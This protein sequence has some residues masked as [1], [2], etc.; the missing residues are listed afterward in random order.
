MRPDKTRPYRSPRRR[1]QAAETRRHI[2]DA[3][4][5]LFVDRGLGATS[6]ADIARA[7]G[8]ATPTVY[9]SFGSKSALLLAVLDQLT[10]AAG[11]EGMRE[12]LRSHGDDPRAQLAAYVHFDRVLFEQGRDIIGVGLRARSDPEIDAWFSEGE[13]RRRA[14][15]APVVRG[16][17]RAGVLRPGL[18]E[19][20]AG[21]ILWALT[22]PAVYQ[23]FVVESGWSPSAFERWL[24]EL[25]EKTLLA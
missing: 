9:A 1:A 7:A 18:G 17:H 10:A 24:R 11:I 20:R 19:R 6:V 23:L 3:A 13:R 25:L 16:W 8:V 21:D 4:Q 14:G 12:A 2:V 15:Q 22:G 5:S